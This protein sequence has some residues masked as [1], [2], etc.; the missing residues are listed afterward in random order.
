MSPKWPF[1]MQMPDLS[2]LL[3][4]FG[5]LVQ[6]Y[7]TLQGMS[8]EQVAQAVSITP[9]ALREIE[10]GRRAVNRGL[11]VELANLFKLKGDDRS[12]FIDSAEMSSHTMRALMGKEEKPSDHPPLLAAI[13]VFLIAD[14][15]GYTHYTVEHGDEAAARLTQQFAELAHTAVEQ[16]GGQLVEVRGDEIL[17]VFASARSALRAAQVLQVRCGESAQ[18]GEEGPLCVGIGLDVGEAAPVDGGGY[19]GAALNRAARLCSL[20]GAGEVL[21]SPGLVYLAP[22]VEGITYVPRGQEQLKGFDGLTPIILASATPL[23]S[24][25]ASE[26]ADESGGTRNI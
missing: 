6:H 20:A 24:A 5:G 15:R 10:V 2:N 7:R 3:P 17:A 23:V 16:E 8:V 9:Q 13:L 18:P 22:R 11:A 19:R 26:V 4:S 12:S 21:V 25:P 1:N 14:I